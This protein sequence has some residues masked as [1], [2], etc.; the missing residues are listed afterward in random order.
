MRKIVMAV[1][2]LALSGCITT[3]GPAPRAA[4]PTNIATPPHVTRIRAVQ[5]FLDVVQ[6]VEPVASVNAALAPAP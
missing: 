2:A 4:S 3:T 5:N 1:V 6:R